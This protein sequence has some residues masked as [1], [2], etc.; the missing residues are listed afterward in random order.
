MY[1][2]IYIYIYIYYDY[3]T[4]IST[5]SLLTTLVTSLDLY[6]PLPQITATDMG[7]PPLSTTVVLY[8]RVEDV[9]DERPVFDSPLTIAAARGSSHVV[10][11][12]NA[13]VN[14]TA[15]VGTPLLR[16]SS[17]DH[18]RGVNAEVVYQLLN[19]LDVLVRCT[20][21]MCVY[22]CVCVCVCVCV[23]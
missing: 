5:G 4:Y 9:D 7:I 15:P 21:Y 3:D 13:E 22:V 2:Y 1:T 20:S 6:S 12:Y 23:G 16:V 19:H 17:L 11:L 18:D 10:A 8:I 14:E